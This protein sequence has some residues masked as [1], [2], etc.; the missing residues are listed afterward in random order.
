MAGFKGKQNNYLDKVNRVY[1]CRLQQL[2]L[3]HLNGVRVTGL[4]QDLE[5]DGIGHEKEAREEEA[6]AFQVAIREQ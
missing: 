3:W 2:R 6:L 1:D 4:T 5:Q